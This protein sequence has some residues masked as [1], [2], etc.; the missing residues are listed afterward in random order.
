MFCLLKEKRKKFQP[1]SLFWLLEREVR[2][3]VARRISL[4]RSNWNFKQGAPTCRSECWKPPTGR[5]VECTWRSGRA[6]SRKP[7]R[8][9]GVPKKFF[10]VCDLLKNLQPSNQLFMHL[11]ELSGIAYLRSIVVN[12]ISFW[13]YQK[14]KLY[15]KLVTRKNPKTLHIFLKIKIAPLRETQHSKNDIGLVECES[16]KLWPSH[17]RL[18]SIMW[19]NMGIRYFQDSL[20]TNFPLRFL[21]IIKQRKQTPV[22]HISPQYR[23]GFFL[24]L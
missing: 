18:E 10:R 22:T 12:Y 15:K 23:V 24:D 11:Y 2:I 6:R 4:R 20:D 8:I 5:R 17:L 3:A 9:Q 7:W 13:L 14:M 21:R 1:I 16:W 19:T